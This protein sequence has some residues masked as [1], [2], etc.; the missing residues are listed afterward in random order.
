MKPPSG[1]G[2]QAGAAD[3]V[4]F[5]NLRKARVFD[6]RLPWRGYEIR[7]QTRE[8]PH[9]VEIFRIGAD[10]RTAY[11]HGIPGATVE[12]LVAAFAWIDAKTGEA[13]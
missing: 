10:G 2:G 7:V 11:A 1:Q 4:V 13:P 6:L 8:T 3:I 5:A 9:G 12:S